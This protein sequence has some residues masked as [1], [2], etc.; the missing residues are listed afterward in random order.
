MRFLTFNL[1]HGLSPSTPV[2][3]EALEPV[4]RR[5]LREAKQLETLAQV[6]PA[7][8]FF[9]EVN[10]VASRGPEIASHLESDC[11]TQLD[12][13]GLK[14]FGVGIPLNLN[15]GLMTAVAKR[16]PLKKIGA[17]SLSRP[18]VNL[19]HRWAS[20]QLREER[21]ALFS[22]TMLPKWGKV[23]LVNTHIH[24]GLEAT[25]DLLEKLTQSAKELELSDT[26]VSELRERF[27]KGNARRKQ[28]LDVLLKNV[29]KLGKRYAAVVMAGDFNASPE[30]ETATALR[31]LGFRD[32]WREVRGSEPGYTFDPPANRANHLLQVNFPL[33]LI[34]EDLSFSARVKESLLAMAREQERR[35]RRIDYL[36]LKT[37]GLDVRVK[38]AELV[39]LPDKDGLAPSDH[40]GV[41]ADLEV[42]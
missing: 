6:A 38:S 29:E 7:I 41:S 17:V 25:P 21:F 20:W 42:E 3:F 22:E 30:S 8:S 9:Q 15:S 36:W 27:L 2:A 12:L 39:G 34:V 13:V 23:L 11:V 31:E 1:W 26:M 10:P 24:H 14:L 28:E 16:Y 37:N 40:F 33:T 32:V 19:V 18:G 5:E 4:A 35:P